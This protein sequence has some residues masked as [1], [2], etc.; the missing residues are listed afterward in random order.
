[1]PLYYLNIA[2]LVTIQGQDRRLTVS[3]FHFENG[4]HMR[5]GES[6]HDSW[7]LDSSRYVF[8]SKR[9]NAIRQCSPNV[10]RPEAI[11][12]TYLVELMLAIGAF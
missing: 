3:R 9:F 11:N 5:G 6:R 12:L 4:G 7:I 8:D 1:M 2:G 10:A